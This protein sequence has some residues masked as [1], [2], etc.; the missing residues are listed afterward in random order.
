LWV[1]R[2]KSWTTSKQINPLFSPLNHNLAS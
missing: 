2:V 1:E